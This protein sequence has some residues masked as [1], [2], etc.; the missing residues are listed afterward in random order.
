MAT[1]YCIYKK[2]WGDIEAWEY[3]D[4]LEEACQ[5]WYIRD[6]IEKYGV[7]EV[8]PI[9]MNKVGGYHT[10]YKPECIA[11]IESD[12]WPSL[13]THYDLFR[14]LV[15]GKN[16]KCGWIDTLG[17]T[18]SCPYMGHASRASELVHM[19][20]S[21]EYPKYTLV[22]KGINAPDDFLLN[23]GWIKVMQGQ[24]AHIYYDDKVSN[25]A[26]KKLLEVEKG[27]NSI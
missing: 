26:L 16:F 5:Y 15:N 27:K 19:Y 25:E 24:P 11:I 8:M 20:Y 7:E 13:S 21:T 14:G 18:Y 1:K 22:E 4:D 17:N 2:S 9:V 23:K 3:I 10:F 12:D 6:V